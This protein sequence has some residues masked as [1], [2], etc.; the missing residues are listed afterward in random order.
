[1]STKP[2][3]FLHAIFFF[4]RQCSLIRIRFWISSDLGIDFEDVLSQRL[5]CEDIHHT[6]PGEAEH[7]RR[8]ARLVYTWAWQQSHRVK[9]SQLWNWVEVGN[10]TVEG[11]LIFAPDADPSLPP[12]K[13]SLPATSVTPSVILLGLGMIAQSNPVAVLSYLEP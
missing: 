11:S 8:E 7:G 3:N 5:V 1:M 10:F 9:H 2:L 12:Q 4:L 6:V 13:P